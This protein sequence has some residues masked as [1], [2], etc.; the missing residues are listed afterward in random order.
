MSFANSVDRD[1][2]I[3]TGTYPN[4]RTFTFGARFTF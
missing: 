1:G 4:P 2:G 3:D